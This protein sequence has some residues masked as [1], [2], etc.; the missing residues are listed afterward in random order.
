MKTNGKL[1]NSI[2]SLFMCLLTVMPIASVKQ[3]DLRTVEVNQSAENIDNN[4]CYEMFD[5]SDSK[6]WD[7][8]YLTCNSGGGGDNYISGDF[9][10]TNASS[11]IHNLL[12][13]GTSKTANFEKFVYDHYVNKFNL[14][15]IFSIKTIKVKEKEVKKHVFPK[16]SAFYVA[17]LE[18]GK[19]N[20]L[21]YKFTFHQAIDVVSYTVGFF[22]SKNRSLPTEAMTEDIASAMHNIYQFIITTQAKDPKKLV[23]I[24]TENNLD[25]AKVVYTYSTKKKQSLKLQRITVNQPYHYTLKNYHEEIMIFTGKNSW[26]Y[27]FVKF[28]A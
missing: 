24:Y 23:A 27:N 20:V 8:N 3:D 25:A 6:T 26:G 10:L 28:D 17:I 9:D 21:P 13:G 12:F 15:H 1:L 16:D 22:K 2:V 7:I 14:L 18:N 11:V 4:L 5:P 19:I